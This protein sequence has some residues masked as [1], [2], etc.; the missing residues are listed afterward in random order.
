MAVAS[1]PGGA[2]PLGTAP[3]ARAAVGGAM[4]ATTHEW[5]SSGRTRRR[6]GRRYGTTR[7][8]HQ[9]RRLDDLDGRD[10]D[11]NDG[12]EMAKKMKEAKKGA[13]P[14][15]LAPPPSPSATSCI[16]DHCY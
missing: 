15:F 1:A 16:V 6:I 9:R 4:A 8:V 5:R 13:T 2:A 7:T 11:D 10:V 12:S 14:T 3:R